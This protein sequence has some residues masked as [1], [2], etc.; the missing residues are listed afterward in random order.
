MATEPAPDLVVKRGPE[1]APDARLR[2]L[3][4]PNGSSGVRG[5]M[6][7]EVVLLLFVLALAVAFG[8]NKSIFWS[9]GNLQN[10]SSQGAVLAMAAAGEIFPILIGGID[11]SVGGLISTLSIFAVELSHHMPVLLAFL[12]TVAIGIGIG[13]VNGL[14]V[15]FARVSPII[16]TLGTWQIL[17]GFNLWYTSG[18]PVTNYSSSYSALGNRNV[19]FLPASAALAVV[20]VIAAWVILTRTRFG[21]HVYALG[22]N[23]EAARLSGVRTTLVTIGAYAVCSM[24]TAIGA[25][26]LSSQTSTGNP[27][28]GGGFEIQAIAAVFI[29]GIAWGGGAGSVF[30][31]LLGVTLVTVLGNGLDLAA[32]SSDIQTMV[33]GALVVVAVALNARRKRAGGG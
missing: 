22:G 27:T 24:F 33:T 2:R 4:R 18:L 19:W 11:L 26:A 9:G 1:D 21:R 12:I 3:L 29:G 15:T 20:V 14:L 10:L 8:F 13:L 28:L 23:F 17:V 16:A 6:T 5:Y 30:G 25:I 32:V 7:Q 31:A